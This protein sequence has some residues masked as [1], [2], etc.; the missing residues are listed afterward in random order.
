MGVITLFDWKHSSGGRAASASMDMIP[1]FGRQ[2]SSGYYRSWLLKLIIALPPLRAPRRICIVF[3][4]EGPGPIIGSLRSGTFTL[5]Y[6][7]G[8]EWE[9]SPEY[10]CCCCTS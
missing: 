7:Q 5:F 1:P 9:A 10:L 8:K 6:M 2:N 4:L 3:R